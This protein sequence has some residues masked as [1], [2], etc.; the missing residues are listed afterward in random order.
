MV[1]IENP[2]LPVATIGD[3]D[4]V[5]QGE[6]A[7]A[8]GNPLGHELSG[9]VTA[10]VISAVNRT[11][12]IDGRTMNLIQTDAAIS[13]GNSG[14]ALI[15]SKGEVIGMNTVKASISSTGAEGLGFAIPSNEF[16]S[17]AKEL[18]EHGKI[19]RPGLGIMGK[20][21]PKDYA[22]E[23]GYPQ[24]IVVVRVVPD[25]PADK[26]GII[27]GDVLIE[28][29]ENEIETFDDLSAVIKEHKVG[30]VLKIKVWRDGDELTLPVKLE[31]LQ[32]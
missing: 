21:I 30:D 18:I 24:G 28:A 25:G 8:I 9:T 14:G 13:P 26:A 1:K 20:T 5:K 6:L 16:I 23:I 32:N 29:D 19:E 31:Q 22:E 7:I 12:Q 15:N 11:L 4:E 17:I 10:G 3:S 2:D 27:P